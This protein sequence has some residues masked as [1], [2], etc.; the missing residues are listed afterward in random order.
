METETAVAFAGTAIFIL[1]V[2]G[3]RIRKHGWAALKWPLRM[4]IITS[5]A[6]I[7]VLSILFFLL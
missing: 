3:G 2:I 1:L 6:V 5:S 4:I 7:I